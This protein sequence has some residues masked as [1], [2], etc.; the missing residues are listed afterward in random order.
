M[1]SEARLDLEAVKKEAASNALQEA[2]A[3][4]LGVA[5]YMRPA[6]VLPV[7]LTDAVP[8]AAADEKGR[9]FFNPYFVAALTPD[10]LYGVMA[11]ELL[12]VVMRHP[13]ERMMRAIQEAEDTLQLDLGL[14]P[15]PRLKETARELA[16]WA[17]DAEVNPLVRDMRFSLPE[18][19]EIDIYF[20]GQKIRTWKLDLVFPEKF[21]SEKGKLGEEYLWELLDLIAGHK[22]CEGFKRPQGGEGQNQDQGQEGLDALWRFLERFSALDDASGSGSS[23]KEEDDEKAQARREAFRHLLEELDRQGIGFPLE[24][25]ELLRNEVAHRVLEHSQSQGNVPEGLKR[26]AEERLKPKAN[27]RAI[28]RKA[29]RKGYV[30]LREKVH[31]TYLRQNKRSHVYRPVIMPGGYTLT[32]QVA[33]VVDTSGSVDDRM[34]A[35]A[36]AETR[37]IVRGMGRAT[38]Y[39]VDAAVHHV[40]RA[41]G[42]HEIELYGGGGTDM[43]V[44]IERAVKDGHDLVVVLTDGHTDWPAHPPKRGIKV[45]AGVIGNGPAP[46]ETWIQVVRIKE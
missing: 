12:H 2:R 4:V 45:I 7:I 22:A 31:P 19:K 26:W 28:L 43:G 11:H 5:R 40:Q 15:S 27:W 36:L 3:V 34:L 18:G 16:N 37:E 25:L 32:P 33:V 24:E 23:G 44:G 20:E 8:T 6:F 13:G 10:E 46:E 21:C 14:E 38:V 39:S 41:F 17:Y 30:D 35:Q 9:L 42:G 1:Q 29:V